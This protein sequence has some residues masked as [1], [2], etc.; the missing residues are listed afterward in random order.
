MYSLIFLSC[1]QGQP[2]EDGK[3]NVISANVN[4]MRLDSFSFSRGGG[5]G[6]V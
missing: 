3:C 6:E 5:R 4:L 2:E 1:D